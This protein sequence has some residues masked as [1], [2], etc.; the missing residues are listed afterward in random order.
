MQ[1]LVLEFNAGKY[2][3][4]TWYGWN[5]DI[6]LTVAVYDS[7]P[8]TTP[9]ATNS[10][11]PSTTPSLVNISLSFS[12]PLIGSTTYYIAIYNDFSSY[13]KSRTLIQASTVKILG[14]TGTSSN[15]IYVKTN[16]EYILADETAYGEIISH[17]ADTDNP[18]SVTYTQVGAAATSHTHDYVPTSRTVNSKALSSNITLSASDV[19][20]VPT[21]R[22]VN[23]KELSSNITLSAA[24][25]SAATSTHVHGNLTNDGK[26]GSTASLFVVTGSGGGITV[27]SGL[28]S[29]AYMRIFYDD[30]EPASP[31]NG[32]LWFPAAT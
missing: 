32:D 27:A 12:T 13:D 16:G 26:I 3:S 11:V 28:A 24:D 31:A 8:S 2:I 5:L 7:S 25:V 23:S 15:G 18:H 9:V 20:A 22:T 30:T 29:R 10:F 17:E 4:G 19:S 1:N 14:V 21:T 6:P